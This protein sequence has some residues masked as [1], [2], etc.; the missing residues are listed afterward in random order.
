MPRQGPADKARTPPHLRPNHVIT[1]IRPKKHQAPNLATFHVPL[2]FNKLDMRDYLFH[3]Y[4][5]RTTG[6][7]SYINQKAP[8]RKG[9][10]RGR[11]YRPQSV[12]FMI[13]ELERPFVWP[14]PPAEDAR[15]AF[16]YGVFKETQKWREVTHDEQLV[17]NRGEIQLRTEKD[18]GD[19]RRKL[20]EMADAYRSG[21]LEWK[22]NVALDEIWER[23][24]NDVPDERAVES[25]R[26]EKAADSVVMEQEDKKTG[27]FK[28][29]KR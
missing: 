27:G 24:R 11:W 23:V 7:R 1:M 20:A 5:V 10:H 4:N 16:D 26:E 17:R 21:K 9:G 19:E 29:K 15:E 3:V 13:A 18:E 22:N 6:M 12:K 14:D 25:A 8:Q 2:T 28:S